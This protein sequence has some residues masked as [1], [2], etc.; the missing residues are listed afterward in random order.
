M[1][2]LK[3]TYYHQEEALEENS[4]F[5]G[6]ALEKNA[7]SD[8]FGLS[9]YRYGFQG[10]ERD[11][12]IKG[13]GNSLNYKYRMHDSRLGRFFSIDP[14]Y[15]DYPHNSVYAFSENRV[16]DAIE[17]EGLE[18]FDI[19]FID[20]S[21]AQIRLTDIDKIDVLVLSFSDPT[22]ATSEMQ[23]R[24]KQ[25]INTYE[26]GYSSVSYGDQ[27]LREKG[28][29]VPPAT[30]NTPVFAF[31]MGGL[32]QPAEKQ[33]SAGYGYITFGGD[34][35]SESDL[36]RVGS[37]PDDY[38]AMEVYFENNDLQQPFLEQMEAAGYDPTMINFKDAPTTEGATTEG[39]A[40]E[41]EFIEYVEPESN[42][43]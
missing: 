13:L 9:A 12:E 38:G 5:S 30:T 43:G 42:S 10:Q 27:V 26:F 1:G 22:K 33:K 40:M 31:R 16:I 34:L 6:K 32:D 20:N 21:V 28:Q 19:D 2:C 4:F 39:A 14:L 17:L 3:L 29:P 36:V 8:F 35:S 23:Q 18:K 24:I 25:K 41:V 37:M 15:K 7:P 11:D